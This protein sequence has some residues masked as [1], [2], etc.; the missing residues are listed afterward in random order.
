[1]RKKAFTLVEAMI[2]M[3]IMAAVLGFGTV[4]IFRF[5]DYIELQNGYADITSFLRSIQNSAR[6]SVAYDESGGQPIVP[7]Y[8]AVWFTNEDFSLFACNDR[9]NNNIDC[10]P[11]SRNQQTP[12]FSN[13]NFEFGSTCGNRL[14][15]FERSTADLIRIRGNVN[16]SGI[17]NGDPDTFGEC[18]ITV[19][20][21]NSNSTREI[22][23]NLTQNSINV[24]N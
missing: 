11:L 10:V 24:D 6:N 13:V 15:A 22:S 21:T 19:V 5:R 12:N 4:G 20:H 2:V 16:S 1:M 3:G 8:Y 17:S 18:D 23:L 14:Y 7:D 9:N